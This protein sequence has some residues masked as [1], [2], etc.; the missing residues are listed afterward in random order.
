[1]RQ[2][3]AD[4]IPH[5]NRVL[6][7]W[8]LGSLISISADTWNTSARIMIMIWMIPVV[9]VLLAVVSALMGKEMYKLYTGEDR[10]AETLQVIFYTIAFVLNIFIIRRLWVQRLRSIGIIYFRI[11]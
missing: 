7:R 10:I 9:V 4:Q 5:G 11:R 6:G 1:M 2:K 3:T 8:S